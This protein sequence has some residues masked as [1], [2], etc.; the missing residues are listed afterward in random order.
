MSNMKKMMMAAWVCAMLLVACSIEDN[1]RQQN[2]YLNE[3]TSQGLYGNNEFDGEF[4][5]NWMVNGE[6]VGSSLLQVSM[7]ANVLELPFQWLHHTIFP[8]AKEVKWPEWIYEPDIWG[9]RIALTGYSDDTNYFTV[10]G[11]EHNQ[12]VIVDGKTMDYTVYFSKDNSIAIY[13]KNWDAWS[14]ITPIDSIRVYDETA[15]EVVDVKRFTP[16]INLSFNSTKRTK[17]RDSGN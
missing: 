5:I 14:A 10:K 2:P 8:D 4:A 11:T 9:M 6:V 17:A 15:R 13:Y 1:D 12:Q 3:G 7:G 16:A